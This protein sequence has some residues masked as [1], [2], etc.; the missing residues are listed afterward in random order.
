M[1]LNA[2]INPGYLGN[3]NITPDRI[4]VSDEQTCVFSTCTFWYL[5]QWE[6]RGELQDQG[7][8]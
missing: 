7:N 3:F 8:M 4:I 1:V 2:C 6:Y 5:W